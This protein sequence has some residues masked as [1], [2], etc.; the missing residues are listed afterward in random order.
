MIPCV[1]SYIPTH[2]YLDVDKILQSESVSTWWHPIRIFNYI[3]NSEIFFYSILWLL[4][5][6]PLVYLDHDRI[7][8]SE[9]VSIELV[10]T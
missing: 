9:I 3:F 1:E 5:L 8:Q 6:N 4:W 7:P 10:S 2:K